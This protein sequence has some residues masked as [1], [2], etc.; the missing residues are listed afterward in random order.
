[1]VIL[2]EKVVLCPLASVAAVLLWFRIV[3]GEA[4]MSQGLE[5]EQ[6]VVLLAPPF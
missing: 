2:T 5:V 1:M 6:L 3:V 4:V